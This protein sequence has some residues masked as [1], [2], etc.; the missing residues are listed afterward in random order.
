MLTAQAGPGLLIVDNLRAA[1][2]SVPELSPE[3]VAKIATLLPPLTF[4]RNPVDTGRPGPDFAKVLRALADDDA[5]DAVVMFA[6]HEPAA[7]DAPAVLREAA[8]TIAKPIVFGTA[9]HRRARRHGGDA[10]RARRDRRALPDIAGA[11]RA[12]SDRARPRDA[13]AQYRLRSSG[14]S[15]APAAQLNAGTFVPRLPGPLDEAGGKGR[16]W[17]ATASPYAKVGGLRLA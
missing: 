16:C 14:R 15:E 5:I 13:R 2:V 7:L 9:E 17:R 8:G 1:G 3:T 11:A 10:R 6:L 4:M 12:R